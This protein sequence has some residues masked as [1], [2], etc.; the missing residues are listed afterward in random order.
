MGKAKFDWTEEAIARLHQLVD[1]KLTA[2]EIAAQLGGGLTRN[3]IIGKTHREK[4]RLQTPPLWRRKPAEPA[5]PVDAPIK[6]FRVL[7]PV[8]HDRGVPYLQLERWHCK[9]V[10][11][12]RGRDGLVLCCGRQRCRDVNGS[13]TPWCAEHLELYTGRAYAPRRLRGRYENR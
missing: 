9:A 12:S 6:P 1:D 7:A 11:D 5:R 10:M 4:I 13:D 3:A 8:R 2:Q